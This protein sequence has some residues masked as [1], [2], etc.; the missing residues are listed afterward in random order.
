ML[1]NCVSP[2]RLGTT[3]PYSMVSEQGSR[4][5][6]SS[7]CHEAPLTSFLP[8]PN[9]VTVLAR[10]DVDLVAFRRGSELQA[11]HRRAEPRHGVAER[12]R[13]EMS[14][15]GCTA[16]GCRCSAS[17]SARCVSAVGGGRDRSPPP[18]RPCATRAS[19]A[20]CRMV[21]KRRARRPAGGMPRRRRAGRTATG[22]V[23]RRRRGHGYR[24]GPAAA[25]TSRLR[26]GAP[27][28]T[29]ACRPAISKPAARSR[30]SS[31]AP[32]AASRSRGGLQPGVV[33]QRAATDLQRWSRDRPWP[34]LLANALSQIG[35]GD[36][37]AQPH[38][39]QPVGLAE[40]AQ[41]HRARRQVAAPDSPRS[42][43]SR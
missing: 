5:K 8:S 17:S 23:C 30:P 18:P 42:A 19:A 3:T 31:R 10:D 4:M 43:G 33:A 1:R 36:R 29:R 2:P 11:L 12:H 40:G 6:L 32:S 24:A 15:R 39:R 13:R 34:E 35:L 14:G 7:V 37:E 25:P 21:I 9:Y 16:R 28:G 27:A 41:H 26:H 22:P 38:A 20:A